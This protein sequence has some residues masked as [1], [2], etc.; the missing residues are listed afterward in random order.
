MH[1]YLLLAITCVLLAFS[2]AA[3]AEPNFKEAISPEV[4][5]D[6]HITFRIYAPNAAKVSVRGD[7]FS[8]DLTKNADGLWTLTVGPE[9]PGVYSYQFSV[10]G[11]PTLD[12]RN[13]NT[14]RYVPTT[15]LVE[16]HS[17]P[18]ALWEIQ[19]VKHGTVHTEWYTSKALGTGRRLRVY[20]PPDYSEGSGKYPVLYLLHGY[21]DDDSAWTDCGRANFILDNLIANGKAKPMIIVMPYGHT[22]DPFT[23]TEE[24]D[25]A[26]FPK[27]IQGHL[28]EDVIPFIESKYRVDKNRS[29]RAIAGLSMGGA[30]SLMIGL[31]NLDKFASIGAFSSGM[32]TKEEF[33]K[34][35]PT[36]AAQLNS[37]L[38]LFWVACGKNDSL[39]KLNRDIVDTAKA[40]GVAVTWTSSDGS[41]EWSVWRGYLSQMAPLLFR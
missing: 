17:D 23:A 24:S 39:Y 1:P 28:I 38:K 18:P 31:N 6:G 30:Q 33:E 5:A 8:G 34:M 41:H 25:W 12:P 13:P 21:G 26:N 4:S 32:I 11:V 16:V 36:D 7:C 27:K 10:D 2:C 15:S 40:K 35:L 20:T 29:S 9:K 14:K 37:H 3:Q 19:P 22:F